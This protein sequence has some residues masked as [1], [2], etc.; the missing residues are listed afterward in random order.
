MLLLLLLT[1]L[2][3]LVVSVPTLPFVVDVVVVVDFS[4]FSAGASIA[5]FL[6][7]NSSSLSLL[8]T[9]SVT[10]LLSS[11]CFCP[12][13]TTFFPPGGLIALVGKFAFR[14]TLCSSSFTFFSLSLRTNFARKEATIAAT[15]SEAK[16][17]N[18]EPE[19]L[20]SL[21]FPPLP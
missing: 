1:L 20:S 3:L 4:A 15:P 19:K 7:F 6:L 11:S 14:L 12:T 10:R 8:I 9:F 18:R 21:L 2:L 16:G 5:A 17:T 13:Y